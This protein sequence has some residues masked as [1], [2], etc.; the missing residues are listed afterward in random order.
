MP[1]LGWGP[2]DALYFFGYALA[3]YFSLPFL[4]ASTRLV[5]MRPNGVVVDFPS[6]FD[7]HSR[8]QAFHFDRSGLLYRHDYTAS[9]VGFWATGSHFSTDY[10]DIDGLWLAR[11]RRVRARLGR[12]ATPIPVLH[13]RL[14]DFS[15]RLE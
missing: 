10:A 8:R 4:L 15:V 1:R 12:L 13:A 6:G 14:E 7:T 11:R 3:N 9:V 5:R 2:L